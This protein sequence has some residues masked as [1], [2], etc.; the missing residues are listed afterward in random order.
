MLLEFQEQRRIRKLFHSR[1]VLI[2]LIILALLLA[3]AVWGIYVK[4][5][6]S[7]AITEKAETDLA[8]LEDRQ[9]M[10]AL[11]IESLNTD[12]GKERELRDR[13]GVVKEGETLVVLVGDDTGEKPL[14]HEE[15]SLWQKFL[16]YLKNGR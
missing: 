12:E 4:Y 11:S 15:K 10:L 7:L 5:E 13:F 14:K 8:A 9:K 2:I 1:Y 6:R 16:D 3:R